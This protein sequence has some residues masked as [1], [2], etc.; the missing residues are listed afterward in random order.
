MCSI[1]FFLV[2]EQLYC[3]L[4]VRFSSWN[5]FNVF[6][7]FLSRLGTVLVCLVVLPEM[8]ADPD[9]FILPDPGPHPKSL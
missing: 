2:L 5:S 8:V 7:L 6:C 3:A 9:A 4:F 1:C